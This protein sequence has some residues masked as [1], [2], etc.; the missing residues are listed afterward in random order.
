MS[1]R[2]NRR[3]HAVHSLITVFIVVLIW[4]ITMMQND[5]QLTELKVKIHDIF[6]EVNSAEQEAERKAAK[7]RDLLTRRAIEDHFE[8]KK[9]KDAMLEY[10]FD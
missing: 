6:V 1:L 10:S 5:R 8:Q 7:R 4:R 2:L 9:L 3:S